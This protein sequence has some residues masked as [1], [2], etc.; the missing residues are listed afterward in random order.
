LKGKLTEVRDLSL[1]I[2][3]IAENSIK[4]GA[5]RIDITIIEDSAKNLL[6]VEI[7]DDGRG[8]EPEFAET[9]AD[10]FVTSRTTRIVGLG[11]PLLKASA[12][13]ANGNLTIDSVSGKGT[14]V[15]ANFQLNHIDRKPLGNMGET[16][17]ALVANNPETE[18]KYLHRKNGKQFSFNSKEFT[19]TIN[20][21]NFNLSETLLKIKKYFKENSLTQ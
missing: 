10:P 13:I 7:T 18:I 15:T 19:K 5:G 11:L 2:L 6:T 4:A 12:E 8:M 21:K 17:L 3:D 1:H 16:I 9:A 14:K 20:G